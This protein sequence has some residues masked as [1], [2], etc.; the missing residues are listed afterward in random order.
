MT[1]DVKG[2]AMTT[3]VKEK[4]TAT[5]AKGKTK[6]T[7]L[8]EFLSNL[9]TD[10][11]KLGEFLH[12][13][14]AVMSFGNLSEADKTALRSGVSG[15]VAAR[16]AGVSLDQETP[17]PP[18]IGPSPQPPQIGPSPQPPQIGPSPQPPQI[19]STP[20]PPQTG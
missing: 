4:T 9:A 19:G 13:P 11:R 14:E 18:Q 20:Q 10:P 8:K 3:D 6:A 2:K 16:L 7:D 17:Q 5:G 12:A 15:M 1:T